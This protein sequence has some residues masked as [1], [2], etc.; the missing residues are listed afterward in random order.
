MPSRPTPDPRDETERARAR[1]LRL[2]SVRGRSRSELCERLLAAGHSREIVDRLLQ[3]LAETGLIDD[4]KFAEQ[5]A[6]SLGQTRRFGPRRLRQ[7]LARRGIARDTV[8]RAVAQAYGER[9]AA[10][11]MRELAL[12]RYGEELFAAG[13]DPALRRKAQRF[14]LSRGFEA[15][16]VFS[17]FD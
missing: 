15:A 10:E 7:D 14:L 16:D 2:L 3:R 11:V 12:A 17:L 9:P 8:E 4:E 5:R 6:R 13:C 1:A